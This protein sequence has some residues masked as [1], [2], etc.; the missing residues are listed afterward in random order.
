MVIEHTLQHEN[1]MLS[2]E[3]GDLARFKKPCFVFSKKRL[4]E[5]YARIR[6][7]FDTFISTEVAYSYKTNDSVALGKVFANAGS[8]FLVC[9]LR[10]LAEVALFSKKIIYYS[11]CLTLADAK[12]VLKSGVRRFIVDSPSAFAVLMEARGDRKLDVLFRVATG[13]A[14]DGLYPTDTCFGMSFAEAKKLM[15]GVGSDESLR[16][17]VHNHLI[18]QNADIATWKKNSDRLVDF[19]ADLRRSGVAVTCLDLGGGYP[20]QYIGDAVPGIDALVGALKYELLTLQKIFPEMKLIV[21]PGRFLVGPA[22]VLVTHVF[23]TKPVEGRNVAM[24]DVSVYN[25]S[26]DS[27]IVD[28]QLPFVTNSRGKKVRHMIRGNTPD[29]LDVFRKEVV[30]P[31]LSEGDLVVFFNAG[32]YTF[33]ADFLA[34][35]KLE[36]KLI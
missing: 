1:G 11:T 9:N 28:L 31:E 16:L 21:E 10:H 23:H 4:V 2:Y 3:G 6:D 19:I 29:S 32:A 35:E 8:S 27:L 5:Q 30:L 33:N 26:L 34:L 18:S 25:A 20:I 17:G 24:L 12:K 14:S 7:A 22:G 15:L 36:V 13:V